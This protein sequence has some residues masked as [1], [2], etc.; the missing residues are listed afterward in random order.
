VARKFFGVKIKDLKFFDRAVVQGLERGH[1]R[2]LSR[3]GAFVMRDAR[4]SLKT[5][6]ARKTARN[7]IT[8]LRGR[9]GEK[10]KVRVTRT[11]S[12]DGDPPRSVIG[13]LKRGIVFEYEP[14]RR[15]GGRPNVVIGPKLVPQSRLLQSRHPVPAM[16]EQKQK[17]HKFV[18]RRHPRTRKTIN[19]VYPDRPYMKPAFKKN[20][21][22]VSISYKGVVTRR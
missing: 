6:R 19:Q 2:A 1:K 11:P 9:P 10:R 13:T 7:T 17:Y 12:K 21:R 3:F 20:R 22:K 14:A 18:R 8:V 16:H 5:A 4:Q 15:A